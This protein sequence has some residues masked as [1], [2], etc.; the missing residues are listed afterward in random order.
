VIDV[1]VSARRDMAAVRRFFVWMLAVQEDPEEI[2]TDRSAALAAVIAELLPAAVHDTERYAN[3]RMEGDHGRRKAGLRPRRGLKSFRSA[4]TIM[5]GHAVIQNL[6]RGH[7]ELG[8]EARHSRLR[9]AAA[10]GELA[11]AI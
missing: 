4:R 1:V 8:L 11:R 10:F 2:T 9:V 3:H 7:Y 5:A 6:R